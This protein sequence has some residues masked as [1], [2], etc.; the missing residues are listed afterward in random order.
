MAAKAKSVLS[1]VINNEFIKICD[2]SKIGK[3]ITVNRIVT[4]PTPDN[5]YNDGVIRDRGAVAKVIKGAIIENRITATEAYF[6]VA[7]SKIATKDVTIPYVKGKQISGIVN[8]NATEYFPVN[9]N[10][11]LIQYTVLSKVEED[12][13]AKLRL[14]VMAAPADMIGVYYDLAS[15]IG[16]T[17]T[18]VDYVGNSSSQLLSRQIGTNNSI[19]IQ[20]ENDSTIVNIFSNNALCMQRI[21]PY[22][23]SLVVNTVMDKYKVK[24][25]EAM[26]MIQEQNLIH[27]EF[28]G[29]EITESLRYLVNNINRL[30]D[31]FGS[32]NQNIHIEK[33]YITGNAVTINGL[34]PLLNSELRLNLEEINTLKDVTV[35]KKSY[36]DAKEVTKYILNIGALIAPVNFMPK[37]K[38]EAVSKQDYSKLVKLVFAGAVVVSGFL[39]IWPFSQLVPLQ[40]QLEI[41]TSE[42][43]ELSEIETVVSD[44]YAAMDMCTDAKNF[45]TL[46]LSNDDDLEIFISDLEK[47]LPSDVA[48]SNISIS[49]GAVTFTGTASSKESVAS[50]I[51]RL[52]TTNNV[53]NVVIGSEAESKDS[54]GLVTVTFS[55]TCSITAGE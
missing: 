42:N 7:S 23:K 8:A 35:N 34:I 2:L 29:D 10:E 46:T 45:K 22:G 15:T 6:T 25:D 26:K 50:L 55:M 14:R 38:A 40:A 48:M 32:R 9:I 21:I 11:H 43:R 31:F 5:S 20:V 30:I 44:Y 3:T 28:D 4:V 51:D 54:L 1:I 17:V 12:G 49:E 39:I 16:L 33:S 24:Y 52:R 37:D 47:N 41:L 27:K 36:L 13:V 53:S 19:V 18:A